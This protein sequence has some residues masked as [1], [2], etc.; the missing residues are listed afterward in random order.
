ML[1][2]IVTG[3]AAMGLGL[4]VA[5]IVEPLR[6]PRLVVGLLLANFVVVPTV[7]VL[8]GR[9]LPMEEPVAN[10]IILMCCAAGAPFLPKLA[11]VAKGDPGTHLSTRWR[12]AR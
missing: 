3:M 2:F 7:A 10:A 4:T 6:Q 12:R 1:V 5:R 9:L 8:A 11:L